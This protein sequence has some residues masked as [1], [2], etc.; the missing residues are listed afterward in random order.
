MHVHR[1]LL[2]RYFT[3]ISVKYIHTDVKYMHTDD[4]KDVAVRLLRVTQVLFSRMCREF[5]RDRNAYGMTPMH[6]N[7]LVH[8]EIGRL[9]EWLPCLNMIWS[10]LQ[11]EEHSNAVKADLDRHTRI[12]LHIHTHTNTH[13]ALYSLGM[14]S[15]SSCK[16]CMGVCLV[17]I[18]G[19]AA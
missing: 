4:I 14:H 10:H 1:M 5:T 17:S 12:A 11:Q 7:A 16:L 9:M 13:K 2:L 6:M 8:V 18:A 3:S 19:L 15:C